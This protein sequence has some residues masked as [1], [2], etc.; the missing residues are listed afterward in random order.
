VTEFHSRRERPPSIR[1]HF[2]NLRPVFIQ[3]RF[4]TIEVAKRRR[5]G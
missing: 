4:D 5:N 3:E 1:P 2:P